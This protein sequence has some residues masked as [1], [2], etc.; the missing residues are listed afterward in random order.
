[1]LETRYNSSTEIRKAF[2]NENSINSSSSSLILSHTYF[3]ISASYRY[4]CTL[5]YYGEHCNHYCK[6]RD[7]KLGHYHCHP[8]TGELICNAGWTGA[9]CNQG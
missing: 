8:Q 1:M 4:S 9:R 3:N 5:N 7:S 2:R 6:P